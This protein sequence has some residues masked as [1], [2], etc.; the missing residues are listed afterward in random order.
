MGKAHKEAKKAKEAEAIEE[1]T[2][3]ATFAVA[4]YARQL[5]KNEKLVRGK[6]RKLYDGPKADHSKLPVLQT[7][8][9]RWVFLETDR[10]WVKELIGDVGGTKSDE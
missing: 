6:L 9:S 10:E 2:S 7:G 5:G 3:P 1:V 4:K 8:G